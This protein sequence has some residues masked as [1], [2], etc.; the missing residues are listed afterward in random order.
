MCRY[1]SLNIGQYV[2]KN[3]R[4]TKIVPF[5]GPPC[6]VEDKTAFSKKHWQVV[7]PLS[8]KQSLHVIIL[9]TDL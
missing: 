4:R 7:D 3:L 8:L 6:I 1:R 5:F 2:T 9:T